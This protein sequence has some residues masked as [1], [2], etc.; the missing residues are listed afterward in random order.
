MGS[1]SVA[2]TTFPV[3]W[4]EIESVG[5]TTSITLVD[6]FDETTVTGAS[7]IITERV[8]MPEKYCGAVIEIAM[9]FSTMKDDNYKQVPLWNARVEEI[10]KRAMGETALPPDYLPI[11]RDHSGVLPGVPQY[12]SNYPPR[13]S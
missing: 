6:E 12:P 9:I 13:Y 2:S 10:V 4:Y 5:G 11:S 1:L 8:D 7:Y 3:K